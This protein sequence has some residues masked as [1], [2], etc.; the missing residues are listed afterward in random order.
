M[1]ILLFVNTKQ[2]FTEPNKLGGIEILNYELFLYLKKTYNVKLINSITKSIKKICWDI[3]ISSNDASVFNEIQAQRKIL[4]L[5]N[6]LQIEKAIRKKQF[7]P[8]MFNKIETVFVSKYL[9]NNTSK[10]YNFKK[11]FVIPNFLPSVYSKIKF[12]KKYNSKKNIFVWSVQRNKGLEDFIDVWINKIHP[13]NLNCELHIFK[14][15]INKSFLTNYNI[16]FHG[17]LPRNK[18]L[19]FYKKSVGMIC[20]GYDE[21]F[22]LNAIEG[23][24]MGLPVISLGETALNEII[25]NNQN[26]YKVNNL[27]NIHLKIIKFLKLSSKNKTKLSKSSVNFSSKYN[28]E[29]IVKKWNKLIIS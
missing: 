28:F 4:W 16:Y 17:R 24:S 6:K 12:K 7:F 26:G 18:L 9:E 21:T 3:V 5:H 8:I 1:K 23:M 20:L 11:R 13:L 25:I 29:Q 15:N 10:I 19:N 14:K 27:S 22:C 2:N